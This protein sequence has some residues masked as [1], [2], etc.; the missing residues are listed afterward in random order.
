MLQCAERWGRGN[1]PAG[2]QNPGFSRFDNL[3]PGK[4]IACRI[5]R[6]I[7]AIAQ[8]DLQTAN[9]TALSGAQFDILGMTGCFVEH[10][11]NGTGSGRDSLR[12]STSRYQS[13]TY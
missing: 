12:R 6:R 5:P 3:K 11:Q 2:K 10:S 9:A 7:A 13:D 8:G 1:H 4:S